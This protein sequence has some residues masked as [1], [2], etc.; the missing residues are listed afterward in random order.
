MLQISGK[1]LVAEAIS[2]ASSIC[3]PETSF[4]QSGML[5]SKGQWIWQKEMPHWAQRE[6]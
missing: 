2:Q 5:L 1:V 3:S 6:A 4:S